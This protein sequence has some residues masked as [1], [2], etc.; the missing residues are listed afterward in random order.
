MQDTA[1]TLLRNTYKETLD[2][3]V[4]ARNYL[5]YQGGRERPQMDELDRLKMS[6][7]AFRVTSRLT[8]VMAW[9]MGQRAVQTGEISL[10]DALERFPVE[11]DEVCLDDSGREDQAL[12]HGLRSL[13]DRSHQLY[14]RVSRLDEMV[15]R[16]AN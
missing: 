3:M 8:Q 6:C 15:R 16:R 5:A 7:E 9:L 13:L 12:P 10:A 14:R 11:G 2:L 4:E 1:P